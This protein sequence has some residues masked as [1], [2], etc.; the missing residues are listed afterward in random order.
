[1]AT[2]VWDETGKRFYETGVNKGVFYDDEGRGVSWN[3]LTSVEESISDQVQAVHF[4]GLKFNDI[5]TVGDL[6]AV[7]RAWTYPDE[8]LPYEGI[9]EEQKG[10]YVAH[11]TRSKFG[12]S[13]Q[14]KVGN[15]LK[16]LE[17]GYKIHILYNLTALPAQKEYQ[18]LSSD[19]EPLEFEWTLTGIPEYI[20]N[21]RPTAHIILDS[22]R[23]DPWLLEDIE[24]II[25]GDEDNDA[26]L[27]PLKGF[28]T[29]I[30]KWDRLIITDH[31]DGTWS[32]ETPREEQIVMLDDTTFE[33][34]AETVNY[35]DPETYEIWS[36]DKNEED[37]WLR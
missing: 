30:R 2:L 1:M 33:I 7:M 11:Q 21:Y 26:Y 34:T 20:E 35:L 37:I 36:S 15:D 22:R 12:L 16:G 31:G 5:L 18:T 27:P 25:Y 8:F 14:T 23:L 9:L 24:S 3:G 29:F 10:F 13:Y 32:A 6:S 28:A 4:D 17:L 19:T